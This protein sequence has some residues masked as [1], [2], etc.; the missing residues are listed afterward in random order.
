LVVMVVF[1]DMVCLYGW[2][3]C[4]LSAYVILHNFAAQKF[5]DAYAQDSH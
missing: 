1:S 4:G 5:L 3:C 2:L